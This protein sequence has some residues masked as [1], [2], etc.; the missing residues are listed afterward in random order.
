M[1]TKTRKN[2]V[3]NGSASVEVL[4]SIA[5]FM[6]IVLAAFWVSTKVYAAIYGLNA[7]SAGAGLSTIWFW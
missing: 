5:V 6:V 4:L 3:R 2:S 1:K 7:V